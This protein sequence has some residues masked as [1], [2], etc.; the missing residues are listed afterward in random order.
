MKRV[1][2]S[3]HLEMLHIAEAA[4]ADARW[5]P[6]DHD[7][8]LEEAP[9]ETLRYVVV[10]DLYDD[11]VLLISNLWPSLTEA[12]T[13][14]FGDDPRLSSLP[15]EGA[16]WTDSAPGMP[17]VFIEAPAGFDGVVPFEATETSDGAWMA[18]ASVQQTVDAARVGGAMS[19]AALAS[20][21]EADPGLTR[22]LRIGD[23]FAVV[24][25]DPDDVEV[26]ATAEDAPTELIALG[27]ARLYDITRQAR[28]VARA[29]QLSALSPPKPP[30]QLDDEIEESAEKARAWELAGDVEVPVVDTRE[31]G[32]DPRDAQPTV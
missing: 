11:G 29:A 8:A 2:D 30:E 26:A 7:P 1:D 14:Y 28:T 6:E 19:A 31:P 27:A 23:T 16:G 17:L 22:P 5:L 20:T 18:R 4:D 24:I 13:L 25:A 15:D 32:A 10:D 3:R 9:R 12:G 21:E